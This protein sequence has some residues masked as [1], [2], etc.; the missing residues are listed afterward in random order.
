GWSLSHSSFVYS[1]SLPYL[2]HPPC[3]STT[4]LKPF[5][6]SCFAMMPPAAPEPMITKSTSVEGVNWIIT[7]L[8][9]ALKGVP[10]RSRS[11]TG[12]AYR[13]SFVDGRP[14]PFLVRLVLR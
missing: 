6:E 9:D 11:L 2:P 14:L 13:S 10:Y 7:C 5:V 1:C 12:V 4:T 3:S 8:R